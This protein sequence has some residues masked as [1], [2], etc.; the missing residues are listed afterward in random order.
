VL[1]DPVTLFDAGCDRDTLSAIEA[2][3]HPARVV[4]THAHPDHCARAGLF[5][6]DRIW[7]P[8]AS[9]HDVGRLER[10]AERFVWPSVRADWCDYMRRDLGFVDFEAAHSYPPGARFRFGERWAEAVLVP[11]HTV[12]H[13]AFWFPA[14]RLLLTTDVDLTS[15]GPWYGNPESDLDLFIASIQR[16]A[17]LPAE[18]CV[19]SHKGA[20]R[21]HLPARFAA[22]L[23]V[24]DR[25]DAAILH[26]LDRPRAL[27]E[28]VDRAPIYGGY[29]VR[30]SILRMWE[31]E[32]VLRHLL[33]LERRG[34]VERRAWR[35]V[36][37]GTSR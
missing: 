13:H 34:R 12:D 15:F 37:C 6:P 17:T 2:E 9:R 4:L 29:P 25:R 5:A 16:L 22:Y 1:D 24:I 7:A 20:L 27:D 35:W 14:E 10:M 31:A 36:A 30:P 32:M 19:S 28:L 26:C 18:V 3:H 33:R 21:G 11:G 8:W 23:D